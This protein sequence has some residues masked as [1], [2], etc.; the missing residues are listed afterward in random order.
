M[1]VRTVING[2]TF[3][4]AHQ[5]AAVDLGRLPIMRASPKIWHILEII[6]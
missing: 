1:R 4:S 5:K 6:N 3:A 2:G